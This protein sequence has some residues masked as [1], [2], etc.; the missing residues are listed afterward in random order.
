MRSNISDYRIRKS[1]SFAIR[2]AELDTNIAADLL[3]TGALYCYI[4]EKF[5]VV[6]FKNN[7]LQE[8][9]I[10]F[11]AE[12]YKASATF[13]ATGAGVDKFEDF[14]IVHISGEKAFRN[15]FFSRGDD[16]R[17]DYVYFIFQPLILAL[18]KNPEYYYRL[19]PVVKIVNEEIVI[20]DFNYYP[21]GAPYS[22]DEFVS[23]VI[24][25]GDKIKDL[26]LPAA[27]CAAMGIGIEEEKGELFSFED[28]ESVVF[29]VNDLHIKD[30]FEL[31]ELFLSLLFKYQ[32]YTWFGRTL[33]S[34]DNDK[35]SKEEIQLIKNGFQY[36]EVNELYND[37]IINFSEH[38]T[39][40]FY[41][42]SHITITAGDILNSYIP[43]AILDEELAILNTKIV[44]YSKVEENE[45]LEDLLASKKELHLLKQQMTYKYGNVLMA[46]TIMDY[47][48]NKL[49]KINDQI[50][51]IDALLD[52]SFQEKEYRKTEKEKIYE[53]LIGFVSVILSMSAIFEYIIT[54]IY[55]IRY[56]NT[57]MSPADTLLNYLI[58]IFLG[59]IILLVLLSFLKREKK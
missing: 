3:V 37:N 5:D 46:H 20:V 7:K 56:P 58:L 36:E 30:I 55:K 48:I 35:L 53:F 8:T 15:F 40:Q 25:V 45:S 19:Y 24:R 44:A 23:R 21:S 54:P 57:S 28:N 51:R 43:S 52:V 34:V 14:Y 1:F 18:E 9:K 33:I 11:Y 27:Y 59:T 10:D 49:F 22:I 6:R 32:K 12:D 31:S 26:K 29:N 4:D 41:I 39:A 47:A 17:D 13:K 42:F 2:N 50:E 16:Y 38:N